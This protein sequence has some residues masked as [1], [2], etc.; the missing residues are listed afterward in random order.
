MLVDEPRLRELGHDVLEVGERQAL[1][2]GDRLERDGVASEPWRPSSTIR[3]TPYSAFVEKIMVKSYQ[4]G[5]IGRMDDPGDG[6]C[7]SS[8]PRLLTRDGRIWLAGTGVD[9][10]AV[11][12]VARRMAPS[13]VA[14][15]L[16]LTQEQVDL[17]L[18][19]HER[20]PGIGPRP[21]GRAAAE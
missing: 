17:A 2:L 18:A 5:R 3:R 15:R 13:D 9:V 8:S 19:A 4:R 6:V 1:G 16:G 12:D 7:S 11:V 10:A 14:R 20:D 21:G